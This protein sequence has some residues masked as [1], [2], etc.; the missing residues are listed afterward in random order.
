MPTEPKDQEFLPEESNMPFLE[1]LEEFRRRL[2]K[3]FLAVIVCSAIAGY[4]SDDLVKLITHP[5]GGIKLHVTE[6]TGS[7][8]AYLKVALFT[9][10]VTAL[11]FVF[12]QLWAFVSPGL[13]PR[14]KRAILPLVIISTLL[15]LIGATFCYLLVLPLAL[16]ILIGFSEGL[17]TPIITVSSYIT[18]AGLFLLAFGLAFELPVVAYFLGR[19]GLISADFLIK[20]RRYAVVI[21]LIVAALLTPADVFTQLL[22][23]VPLY[24]LYEISIVI[25]R[26]TGADRE[27]KA[28]D[29]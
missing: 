28:V 27:A 20:G 10:I 3:S 24:I 21:I 29:N 23:A 1:H 14:E 13:Y 4:F 7:F 6:V 26:M 2:I 25:V 9:G 8:Y 11:P 5:L 17:F 18:F 15:F 19:I 12:Y 16:H 22:L